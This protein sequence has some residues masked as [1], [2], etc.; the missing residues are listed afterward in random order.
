MEL[1]N[2]LI[3]HC[4]ACGRIVHAEPEAKVPQCCGHA[5][6]KAS[7]E[8]VHGLESG[9]DWDDDLDPE[10]KPTNLEDD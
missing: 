1:H 4:V 10:F 6:V 2:I 7:E 3:Y 9:K 5:M 8:T